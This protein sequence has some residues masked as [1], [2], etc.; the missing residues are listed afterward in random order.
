MVV[1]LGQISDSPE[2]DVAVVAVMVMMP[3]VWSP[4]V[5]SIYLG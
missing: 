5:C 2:V 4:I 3:N 1:F